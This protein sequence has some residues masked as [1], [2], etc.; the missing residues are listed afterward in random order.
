MI[1]K[2]IKFIW[3]K[4]WYNFKDITLLENCLTHPSFFKE[5]NTNKKIDNQFEWLEFLGDRV[6]GLIISS[7]LFKKYNK[8]NEGDLSKKFSYLVQKNFL[9]KISLEIEIDKILLTNLKKNN[10]KM[11][12]SIYSDAVESLIGAIFVDGGYK[13]SYNFVYKF[14]SSYLDINISKIQ[15]PKHFTRTFSAKSKNFLST[16]LL[17]KDHP[18]LHCLL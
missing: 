6:L 3:K 11:L 7:M 9:H 4:Y 1:S 14:W 13:S 10:N 15:D 18:I 8:L 17:L 16:N 5:A 12:L 2:K